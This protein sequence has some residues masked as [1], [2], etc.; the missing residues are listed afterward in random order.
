[1]NK[2]L[3]T[4][5][6]ITG[7]LLTCAVVLF[8][9]FLIFAS[10]TTLKVKPESIITVEGEA[11]KT[12]LSDDEISIMTWNIG[13]GAL[14]QYVDCFLDGG[15]MVTGR[16]EDSVAENISEMEKKISE[17]NPDILYVQE[18]DVDSHRSFNINEL[19]HFRD[20]FGQEY[21][22]SYACNFKA[23]YVPVP[24]SNAMGKVEA[25]VATFSKYNISSS[26][27]VQLPIPF[28]WPVSLLNLKRCLLVSRIP[29]EDQDHEIVLV[30]L[31]L[32]AYDSGE[33]KVRQLKQLIDFLDG[34]YKKGNYVIAGGDF[35]QTFSNCDYGKY[36]NRTEWVCPII[37][38]E[39]YSDLTFIMDDTYPTCRSL[40]KP[41]FDSDR[42]TYQY[43]M[44]DG[45]IV[46]NNISIMNCKTVD[47]G[48]E[49]S[50]HNP[51]IMTL[52][53]N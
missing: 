43:Y 2:S 26:S 22:S 30:N 12:P 20:S 41:Y 10:V 6:I 47:M 11:S 25:G 18:I 19:D 28:K 40:Y 45:F 49:N 32:E 17:M 52:K 5:L 44:L 16:S 13:Y 8:V 53:L 33:G 14:D 34:E 1:M 50:D 29:L 48:F 36:P 39:Q 4:V 7:T 9:S 42:T 23:G 31:H 35:N 46:S 51:V 24:I 21:Q 15:T 37:D 27:R 3:K 38:V